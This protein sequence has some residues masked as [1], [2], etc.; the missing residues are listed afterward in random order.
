MQSTFSGSVKILD[1][2]DYLKPAEEC[3]VIEKSNKTGP[4]KLAQIYFED[5]FRPDLIK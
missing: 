5:D 1:L 2:D 3:V 4:Q